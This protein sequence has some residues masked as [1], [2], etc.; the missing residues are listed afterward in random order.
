[1]RVSPIGIAAAGRP[2]RAAAWARADS[3]LTH[4][5]P[6]CADACAAF[7]AAIAAAIRGGGSPYDT[8]CATAAEPAVRD[9]L[10]RARDAPP[11]DFLRHSGWVLT[12]LQNAFHQLLHAGS[13]EAALVATV[14]RGGDTDTNAAICGALLGAAH[15]EAAVPRRWVNAIL[16]CRPRPE[17]AARRP[18][19]PVYWPVDALELAETLV[20]IRP[21]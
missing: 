4:P 17:A 12:A 14:G 2:E 16:S 1:M 8:A 15:G 6:I 21:D 20:A 7:A 3:A 5:N 19:P 11:A 13:L 10:A 9:A 18:R